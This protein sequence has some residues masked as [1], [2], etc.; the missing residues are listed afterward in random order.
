MLERVRSSLYVD[1]V[2]VCLEVGYQIAI[3]EQEKTIKHDCKSL[4]RTACLHFLS[5]HYFFTLFL[6][7]YTQQQYFQVRAP[8]LPDAHAVPI[9]I[10]KRLHRPPMTISWNHEF[11]FH[12]V[13]YKGMCLCTAKQLIHLFS[14]KLWETLQCKCKMKQE[15]LASNIL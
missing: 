1:E 10:R 5:F 2:F 13:Q 6:L 15:I 3:I 9:I 4:L 7:T 14:S 11:P 8:S 12:N